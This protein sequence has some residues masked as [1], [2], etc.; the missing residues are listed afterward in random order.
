MG[1]Q[2]GSKNSSLRVPQPTAARA[3][4]SANLQ[5]LAKEAQKLPGQVKAMSAS[6]AKAS[7]APKAAA[8][9]PAAPGKTPKK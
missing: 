3:A 2:P 8:P 1:I 9:K 5:K 6:I 4:P 7:P